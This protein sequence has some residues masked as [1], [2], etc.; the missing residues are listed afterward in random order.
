MKNA[1]LTPEFGPPPY[2]H[3]LPYS[4]MPVSD[5]TCIVDWMARRQAIRFQDHLSETLRRAGT[6]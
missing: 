4:Q 1:T 5:L 6:Q 3:T 2:L